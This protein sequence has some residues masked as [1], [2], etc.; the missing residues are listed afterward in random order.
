MTKKFSRMNRRLFGVVAAIAV[1]SS[2]TLAQTPANAP[3]PVRTGAVVPLSLGDAARVAAR[4]S[5]ISRGARLR[6]DEAG[7]R[8]RESRSE[9]LPNLSSYVQEAGRTFKTSTL[10]IDF[11]ATPGNPP[12]FDPQGQVEG[13]INTLDVRGRVQQNLLDF[14]A[15]GRVRSAQAN[16]R[17]SSA[18]ADA[19]A[20][21]AA[22]T[23]TNAYVRAMRADADLRA[24]QADTVLATELLNIA[25]SQ[26]QAGTGVGLDV[27]RARSQLANTRAALIASRNTREH[28]HLDLLRSLALP[29][30]TEIVLTDSLSPAAGGEPLPDEASLVA[31][32]IRNR[33]DILAEDQRVRAA[34]QGLSAIKAERLPSLGLVADDGIIGKNG[35][36]LLNTYT[37]GLQVSL[38]I[39]DGFRR[40]ARVQEQQSVIKEAEIRRHDLEQ[41][42]QVDVRGALI[43]L[44]GAREQLGAATERLSLAEQEVSQ[45]RDRFNAGVA[46]NADVVNASLALTSSR[47]LVNDAETLYQL[48]RVA[49][50]RATGSVTTLK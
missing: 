33:P 36:K 34:R 3:T 31:M 29:V 35:A 10:G 17:A 7:A 9:L 8:V 16:A 22:T 49:L 42:A 26:L 46:G 37:W 39:F 13:P 38:P 28:A 50:A 6:A 45:A 32:A 23:A 21:Q 1:A 5:A 44:S 2:A 15:L 4:Q 11:P 25:Q 48:A 24:R 27:T 20:E 41:Q 43:D 47:T 18:D 12:L 30:G 14:G 40:E 19:T